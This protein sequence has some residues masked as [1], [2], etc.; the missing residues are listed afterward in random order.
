MRSILAVCVL[1]TTCAHALAD[2]WPTWRGPDSRGV[3]LEKSL[4]LKWSPTENVRWKVKLP[5]PGNSTPVV[6]G[7]KVF[8]TQAAD[9]G[10]KRSLMCLDRRDGKPR[11]EQTVEYPDDE[12][13]HNTN[14]H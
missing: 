5:G 3:S 4:P 12:P 8:L 14:P 6:W 2:N 9:K 13:T 1:A 10:H 11:W 7:D